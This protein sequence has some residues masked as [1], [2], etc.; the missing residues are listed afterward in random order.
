MENFHALNFK[1]RKDTSKSSNFFNSGGAPEEPVKLESVYLNLWSSC[2]DQRIKPALSNL[3]TE[4]QSFLRNVRDASIVSDELRESCFYL[5]Y[6]CKKILKRFKDFEFQPVKA[7]KADLTYAGPGVAIAVCNK[8]VKCR[9][10]ELAIIQN[11]DYRIRCHRE[12]WQWAGWG[13]MNKFSN[14]GCP[15]GWCNYRQGIWKNIYWYD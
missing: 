13:W 6:Q 10:A 12:R 2:F 7:R 1:I 14:W 3:R 4:L 15:S 11:S 9:D 5:C 8:D